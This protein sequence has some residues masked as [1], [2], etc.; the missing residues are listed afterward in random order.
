VPEHR[1][2][3]CEQLLERVSVDPGVAHGRPVVRGTRV[4]VATVLDRL[5]DGR[6]LEEILAEYPQLEAAD[7]RACVAY[8]AE[9]TRLH[10]VTVGPGGKPKHDETRWLL[11]RWEREGLIPSAPPGG[12]A[13]TDSIRSDGLDLPAPASGRTLSETLAEMRE[14]ER[15]ADTP[16]AT[17]RRPA[18]G[19]RQAHVI[20]RAP[21]AGQ[22]PGRV[23]MVAVKVLPRPSS[24]VTATL[25]P[26]D[27]ATWRTIARPRP[28]PPVAR[29]RA[30][31]MR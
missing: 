29:S 23:G 3:S 22:R 24:E 4:W 18:H 6:A 21:A 1:Q 19:R 17:P 12:W 9:S 2:Q 20:P 14:E 8:G 31:S 11:A 26:W 10:E 16:A 28:V 27:S 30:L 15:S 13:T 25:P 7:V 5:A